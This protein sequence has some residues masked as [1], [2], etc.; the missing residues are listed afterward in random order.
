MLANRQTQWEMRSGGDD[1]DGESEAFLVLVKERTAHLA[2]L[3]KEPEQ[4][5]CGCQATPYDP[6]IH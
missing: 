4:A 3:P 6:T 1:N 5:V 2:A